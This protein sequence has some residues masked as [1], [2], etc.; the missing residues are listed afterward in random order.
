MGASLANAAITLQLNIVKNYP[1][2][3]P[4]SLT[5]A[6]LQVCKHALAILELAIN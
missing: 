4:R 5:F 6:Q 3:K 1:N 2:K